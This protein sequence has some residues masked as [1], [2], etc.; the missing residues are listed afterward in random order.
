MKTG[1][2]RT[3]SVALTIFLSGFLSGFLSSVAEAETAKKPQRLA[4]AFGG[5][6]S[7]APSPGGFGFALLDFDLG[8]LPR[9]S[10]LHLQFNSDTLTV[11]ID[12]VRYTPSV[13]GGFELRGEGLFAGL[14]QNYVVDGR[15]HND[16][17]FFASYASASTWVKVLN[18]PHYVELAVTGRRWFF[19][20]IP[21]GTS[22]FLVL[23]ADTFVAELRFRYTLWRLKPD[24]SLWEPHRLFPRLDGVAFGVEVGLDVR[25]HTEPWGALDAANFSPPD[26][27]NAP[28]KAPR[29]VKQWAKVG[30]HLGRK[31]RLQ[32]EEQVVLMWGED[33]LSRVRVGGLNPYVVPVG[34]MPW[35]GVLAGRVAAVRLSLHGLVLLRGE[36]SVELG[37]LVDAAVVD[38]V[39]RIGAG[40][41]RP[42][43]LVGVGAFVDAR[44][45]PWQV[46]ARVGYSPTISSPGGVDVLVSVGRVFYK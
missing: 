34:G 6:L 20:R 24:K 27:R 28:S 31:L 32:L 44:L 33:D 11:G 7:L 23:P 35:A 15:S 40:A 13:E 21:N 10:H 16:R 22:P 12:R 41:M 4:L 29:I 18:K 26:L 25:E 30:T 45:G 8:G 36:H 39:D 37:P 9:Q 5:D 19:N 46:D 2:V 43:A 17:A 1:L 3:S 42:G 14:L 38:D